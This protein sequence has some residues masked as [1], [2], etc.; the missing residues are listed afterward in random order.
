VH[1]TYQN[2]QRLFEDEEKLMR[3]K[4]IPTKRK[5]KLSLSPRH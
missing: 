5:K 1:L 4:T 3:R 2:Y